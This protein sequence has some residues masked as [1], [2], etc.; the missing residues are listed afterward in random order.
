MVYLNLSMDSKCDE[1]LSANDLDLLLP[2][3]PSTLRSLNL[4]GSKMN[5]THIPLVLPLTKHLEELGVGR[6]L[7]LKDITQLFVPDQNAPL[8]VQM[9]WIPH[10]L[11]YID[12]SDLSA[13]ELD[14]GTLFGSS[15]PVLR[16]DTAPLEVMELSAEV[17]K[18]LERS[19]SVKRAGWCLKELGR[20]HWL[21]REPSADGARDS[22]ARSW[23]MGA[24]WWG[25]RKIPVSRQ[26]VGGMYGK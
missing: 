15:C 10:T 7:K 2:S 13:E 17:I 25:M 12:V 11:R 14:L 20:R 5:N 21:V 26:D 8:E 4:K 22:G 23:K 18:K 9:S 19:A 1:M 16:S 6:H 24:C 3:L